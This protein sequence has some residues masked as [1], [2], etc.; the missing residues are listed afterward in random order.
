MT[1]SSL[2]LVDTASVVFILR[3]CFAFKKRGSFMTSL[4]SAT[5]KF[6][7]GARNDPSMELVKSARLAF[8]RG[9]L[10]I[11]FGELS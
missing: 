2:G 11:C 8:F 4:D 6:G 9:A 5:G 3:M 1:Y 10:W 7:V